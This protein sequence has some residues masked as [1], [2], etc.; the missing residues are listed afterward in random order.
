TNSNRVGIIG[1]DQP[2]LS[3]TINQLFNQLKDK[4]IRIPIYSGRKGHPPVFSSSYF[5]ELVTVSEDTFGLRDILQ[6]YREYIKL[7]PIDHEQVTLN[8]NHPSDYET[9]RQ[10]K[11]DCY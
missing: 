7:I 5:E 6:R 2:V 11:L 10:K 4:E 8:L 3:Q 1:V 9:A